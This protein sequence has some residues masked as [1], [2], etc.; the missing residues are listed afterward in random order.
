MFL[1]L[2]FKEIASTWLKKKL[3]LENKELEG[4]EDEVPAWASQLVKYFNHDTTE[5]HEE[6][7]RQLRTLNDRMETHN[8]IEVDNSSKLQEILK[9]GVPCRKND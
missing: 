4:K 2:F 6:T 9:Y 1:A 7:H 3:G 8:R 5:H